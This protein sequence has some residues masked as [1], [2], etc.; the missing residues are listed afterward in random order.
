MWGIRVIIPRKLQNQVLEE[1]HRGYPGIVRMKSIARSYTLWPSIDKQLEQVAKSYI[2]CKS[3]KSKP[4]VA[5]L[6]PWLWPSQPWQGVH[7]DFAG[8]FMRKM[9]LILVDGHSKWPE[10]IEMST[11]SS[12]KT[13]ELLQLL[14]ARYGL[15]QLLVSDNGTQ[16]TLE[17]FAR[18]TKV[19]VIKH[20][21]TTPYHPSSNR[22]AE[23]F[24]QIFKKQ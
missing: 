21:R 7:V 18:F 15:L 10:V 23:R 8:P 19:N 14:F 5:P 2:C 13:I 17:E 20:I 24:V 6:H 12:E 22:L 1:L 4:A 9:F 3:V 16:F 11:T